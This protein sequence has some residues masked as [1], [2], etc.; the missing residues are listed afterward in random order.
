MDI[1][2]NI[3]YIYLCCVLAIYLSESIVPVCWCYSSVCLHFVASSLGLQNK[4]LNLFPLK[5]QQRGKGCKKGHKNNTQKYIQTAHRRDDTQQDLHHTQFLL[6]CVYFSIPWSIYWAV[7]WQMQGLHL[8]TLSLCHF[9]M[10]S[11][12]LF[13]FCNCIYHVYLSDVREACCHQ[14]SCWNLLGVLF[15]MHIS[16]SNSVWISFLSSHCRS[17]LISNLISA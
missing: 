10:L 11:S 9:F 4:K 6:F 7:K 13:S 1:G 17:Y 12:V 8:C 5:I 2:K 16:N 3:S 15:S 14:V